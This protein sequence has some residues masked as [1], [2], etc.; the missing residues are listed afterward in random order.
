MS[1]KLIAILRGLV[2]EQAVEIGAALIDAGITR[3]EVPLN[4]PSPLESIRLL[5]DRFAESAEIGA[6]TVLNV[7]DVKAV[8]DTGAGLIVSPNCDA[9]VIN[10]TKKLGLTSLP[11]VM[12]PSEC[13]AALSA[14][15]DG[16]KLFPASLLGPGGLKAIRAV[17]PPEVEVFP[18]GGVAEADM[19]AWVKA[20]ANGFGIG[21]SLFRP[22]DDAGKVSRAAKR[23]VQ[24]YDK[25]RAHVG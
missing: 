24:S 6:G 7:Q 2:P 5:V 14:G 18:V 3:I 12:T 9:A 22:G 4:S 13:F 1:Q 19:A 17:L 10:E 23:H 16:L 20:G 25:A 8:A 15:A 21:S 11:G